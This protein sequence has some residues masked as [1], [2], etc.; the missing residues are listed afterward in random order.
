MAVCTPGFERALLGETAALPGTADHA[1]VP[2]GVEF[3]G[4]LD[5]IYSANL[6]LATANR[7]LLRL[8]E[9]LAQS[10]PMLYNG[11]RRVP[12]ELLIGFHSSFEV[13]AVARHSRLNHTR[14][15]AE[16]ISAA[17]R[18]RLAEFGLAPGPS[19]DSALRFLARL[20]QDRCL[21]SFDTSGEHLHRRG[22]RTH[23]QAAPLRE[24]LAAGVLRECS[25]EQ[26]DLVVDPFCGSGTLVIEAARLGLGIAPGGG[27]GFA[28]EHAAFFQ[29]S[30]WERLRS[31]AVAQTQP[32][33]GWPVRLLGSDLDPRA[34]EAAEANANAAGVADALAFTTADA[35]SL[36]LGRLGAGADR[37]LLVSNLPYGHRLA[38]GQARDLMAAFLARFRR[39]CPGWRF[40]LVSQHPDL[41]PAANLEVTRTLAFR[42][43]GLPVTLS[44]G[45]VPS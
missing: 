33:D 32:A 3:T 9:Y 4:P 11:A 37:P 40:G 29:P 2:G 13:R 8:G 14:R 1:L 35:L 31:E 30:K 28:F 6:R 12:W 17:I 22:Y 20:H 24:T 41:I 21:L 25:F 38:S 23:V 7:L 16:T 45:R 39:D 15:I 43:G 34:V 10:L 19:R 36:D 18:D 26:A 42:N 44:L 5:T 27:R